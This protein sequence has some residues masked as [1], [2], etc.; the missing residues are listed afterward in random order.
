MS[1]PRILVSWSSGKD[2]AWALHVLRQSGTYEVV[3]LLTTI[4]EVAERVAMHAVR[5]T[6]LAAQ[7]A[8]AGL[9]LWEVPIPP[10]CTNEEYEARMSAALQRA[11]AAAVDGIAFGDLFLADIRRYRE[12]R[13]RHTGLTLLF[14]L[15]LQPTDALARAMIAA[16]VR[17]R[18]SCVDPKQLPARFAG[19]EFD[20][21]LLRQ[22]P[23]GVDPCGENGEFHTFAY[24]GPMF[25]YSLAVRV[26]NTTVRDGFVFA[27]LTGGRT[28][29]DG[30]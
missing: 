17:A 29:V 21:D 13:M 3:G 18:L 24:A 14:P 22:L 28:Q 30:E 27:D 25:H 6:L 23:A 4:N 11:R 19:Q 26:G 1:R 2:S 9:P 8:A 16:G 10:A 7:A 5:Q 12:E 20:L 15:W